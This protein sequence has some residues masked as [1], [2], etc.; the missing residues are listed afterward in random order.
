MISKRGAKIDNQGVADKCGIP[1]ISAAI[2]AY[3][4]KAFLAGGFAWL[5]AR[6]EFKNPVLQ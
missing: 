1:A 3:E 6:P 2:L 4:L 5:V